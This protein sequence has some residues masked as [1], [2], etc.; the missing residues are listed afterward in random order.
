[1]SEAFLIHPFNEL[2]VTLDSYGTAER[3]TLWTIVNQVT[4]VGLSLEA[5][6]VDTLLNESVLNTIYT[7]VQCSCRPN[8]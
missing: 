6:T 2:F 8:Q 7:V 3:C 4:V 1:M 5:T